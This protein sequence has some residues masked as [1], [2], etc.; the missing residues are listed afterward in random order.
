MAA[1]KTCSFYRELNNLST[2]D[3]FND[4][5]R[6]K[7]SAKGPYYEVERV[8][9]KRNR[10]GK[11][12]YLVKWKGYG[13]LSNTWEP[14][15]NLNS[16]ALKAYLN[17]KPT[18]ELISSSVDALH[19][20]ILENL[21][22]KSLSPTIIPFR[23]DVFQYLFRGKGKK[24]QDFGNVLLEKQDFSNCSL[25][26]DWDR[27]LDSLGDGTLVEFPIKVRLFM[28][29]SPKNHTVSKEKAIISSPRYFIE[30]LSINC[31][32]KPLRV[33]AN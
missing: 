9:S 23:H 28:S 22:S 14:E 4:Q 18:Q 11:V 1:K 21:A 6:L 26:I 15:E 8:I 7:S 12:E 17:P 33:S 29:R 3:F 13:S 24:S 30:K 16:L 10:K 20:A 2:A 32:K 27:L 5:K 31:K 25:P 19:A